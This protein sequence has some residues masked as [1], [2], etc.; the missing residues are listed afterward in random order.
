AIEAALRS[1]EVFPVASSY[2]ERG[3]LADEAPRE[4][5]I[6]RLLDEVAGLPLKPLKIVCH[7]GNGCAGPIIDLLEKHLPFTFIKVDHEPDPRLP[8]GIPNPL[9]PEKREKASRAVVEHG[10]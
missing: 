8:N 7:A 5:Y 4:R 3:K 2:A 1:S 10:A 9:L 6:A